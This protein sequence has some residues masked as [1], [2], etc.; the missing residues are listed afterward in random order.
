MKYIKFS[1]TIALL[2]VVGILIYY[3]VTNKNQNEKEYERQ[4]N[5][6]EIAD[7]INRNLDE[8]YPVSA[9]QVIK[10]YNKIQKCYYN[11]NCSDEELEVLAKKTQQLMDKDLLAANPLDKFLQNLKNEVA[12]YRAVGRKLSNVILD[13]EADI[14]EY[15]ETKHATINCTY[16]LKDKNNNTSKVVQTF[17]LRKDENNQW[18][19]LGFKIY[20]PEE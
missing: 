20:E 1:I 12:S 15:D 19:I 13:D 8:K 2:S 4:S 11:Y 18:K 17:V 3:N 6:Q 7:V 9:R 14:T 5:N 16:Y 10:Y